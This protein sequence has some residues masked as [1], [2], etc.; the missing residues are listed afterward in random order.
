MIVGEDKLPLLGV[1]GVDALFVEIALDDMTGDVK[2][3]EVDMLPLVVAEPVE[4][5]L[6][7]AL[8]RGDAFMYSIPPSKPSKMIE[9]GAAVGR[10]EDARS[11]SRW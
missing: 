8:K 11:G 7:N 9:V 10:L 4:V 6:S 1:R 3:G 2:A 5:E